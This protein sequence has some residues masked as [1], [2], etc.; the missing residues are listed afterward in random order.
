MVIAPHGKE[1]NSLLGVVGEIII[2]LK[3]I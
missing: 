2:F 3:F 1:I